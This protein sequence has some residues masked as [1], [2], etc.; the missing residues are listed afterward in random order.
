LPQLDETIPFGIYLSTHLSTRRADVGIRG[1][2][3][4][5]LNRVNRP[6][7]VGANSVINSIHRR[8][9]LHVDRDFG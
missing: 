4:S 8:T 9:W 3:T 2:E 1:G 5:R 7:A 6:K